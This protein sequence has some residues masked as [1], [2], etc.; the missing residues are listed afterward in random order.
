MAQPIAKA[1]DEIIEQTA[2]RPHIVYMSPA[3]GS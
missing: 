3:D 1:F 2:V